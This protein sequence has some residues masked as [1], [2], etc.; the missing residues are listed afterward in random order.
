[1][2]RI[3]ASGGRQVDSVFSVA[4]LVLLLKFAPTDF[5]FFA[6]P[7]VFFPLVEDRQLSLP[8]GNEDA[9][10]SDECCKRDLVHFLFMVKSRVKRASP[11]IGASAT[12]ASQQ[13]WRTIVVGISIFRI[14]NPTALGGQYFFYSHSFFNRPCANAHL[15][16]SAVLR[17]KN[18]L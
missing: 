11:A 8:V 14:L 2:M 5:P 9:D 10:N 13:C 17:N 1:M 3:Y 16:R 7:F 15:V 6:F 18:F 12:N 4:I